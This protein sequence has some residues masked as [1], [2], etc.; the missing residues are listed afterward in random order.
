MVFTLF[1]DVWLSNRVGLP[2]FVAD[3]KHVRVLV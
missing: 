3:N 1:T 2:L